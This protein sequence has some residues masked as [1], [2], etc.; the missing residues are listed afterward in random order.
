MAN[1]IFS[2]SMMCADY[3]HLEDEVKALEAAGIDSFHID[4]MDGQFVRNF[5]MGV[6]DL[7][8]IRKVTKK[9]VEAHLMICEPLHY[10]DLFSDIGVNVIYIHPEAE[11]QPASTIEKIISKGMTPAIAINPGTS[12]E[13]II[14]FLNIVDRVMVMSVNP[15]H[16]GQVLLPYVNKKIKK[17]LDLRDEYDFEVFWDGHATIDNIKKYSALGIKGFVLGTAAL[18]GKNRGFA[19]IISELR[20][21]A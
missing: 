17:L 16:A 2:A 4:I 11:Y 1:S 15:G 12:V 19:E 6:H 20:T 21:I 5:G 7:H 9:S 8:Y 13:S 18:F 14:E 10:I 3:G